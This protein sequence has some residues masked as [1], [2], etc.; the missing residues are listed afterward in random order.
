MKVKNST[1][2]YS[3]LLL[4]AT[5]YFRDGLGQNP[6]QGCFGQLDSDPANYLKDPSHPEK[7]FAWPDK[8]PYLAQIDMIFQKKLVL[9]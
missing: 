1:D 8:I 2:L 4:P 5:S 6:T 7:I 9:N 3:P